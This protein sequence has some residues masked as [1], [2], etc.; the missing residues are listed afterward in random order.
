MNRYE[1]GWL[2]FARIT[3]LITQAINIKEDSGDFSQ[4][5]TS[6]LPAELR[7]RLRT[8]RRACCRGDDPAVKIESLEAAKFMK[9]KWLVLGCIEAN[10]CK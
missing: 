6:P 9:I 5:P 7:A 4:N 2:F 8:G 10:F 3:L 1:H